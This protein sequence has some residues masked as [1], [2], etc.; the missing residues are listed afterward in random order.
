MYPYSMANPVKLIIYIDDNWQ[1]LSLVNVWFVVTWCFNIAPLTGMEDIFKE[2]QQWS[3]EVVVEI[4]FPQYAT[5]LNML[6]K[7]LPCETSL[8]SNLATVVFM[9]MHVV[10]ATESTS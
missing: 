1:S 5:A 3:D 8:V 6:D 4:S 7:L 2:D 10:I 9:I